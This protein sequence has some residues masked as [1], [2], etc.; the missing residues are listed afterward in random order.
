MQSRSIRRLARILTKEGHSTSLRELAKIYEIVTPT[1]KPNSGMV[2]RLINGYQPKRASTL[3][4]IPIPPEPPKI[5][6]TRRVLIGAWR[7][8]GSWV[9]PEEYFG[10]KR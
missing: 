8:D 3:A 4:R 9:S 10:G 2:Y 5:E 7:L 6:P 1:G